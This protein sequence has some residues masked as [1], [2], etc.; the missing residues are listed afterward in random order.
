MQYY[1]PLTVNS[2]GFFNLLLNY[3]TVIVAFITVIGHIDISIFMSIVKYKI[4]I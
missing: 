1:S 3:V 2:E 4:K